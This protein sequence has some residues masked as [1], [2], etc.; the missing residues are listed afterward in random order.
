MSHI[1]KNQEIKKKD[2]RYDTSHKSLLGKVTVYEK[3][4][5]E[6]KNLKAV[7]KTEV[8]TLRTLKV[9]TQNVLQFKLDEMTKKMKNEI[10]RLSEEAKRHEE[11]QKNENSKIQVQIDYIK[12]NCESLD[13]ALK[14]KYTNCYILNNYI[15]I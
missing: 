6:F 7:H 3:K 5:S 4:L 2:N 13:K 1:I 9:S 15:L 11:S 10:Y 12:E 14:G 8:A